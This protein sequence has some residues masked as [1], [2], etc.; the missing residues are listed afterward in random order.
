MERNRHMYDTK[1][2]ADICF[3]VGSEGKAE[4]IQAHKYLLISSSPVFEAMVDPLWQDKGDGK[5][6]PPVEIVDI[7]PDAFNEMLRLLKF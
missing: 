5:A 1:V 7:S 4:V 2:A 3:K 6:P